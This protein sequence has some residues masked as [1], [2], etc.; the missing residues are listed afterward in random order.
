MKTFLVIA[1]VVLIAG[2]TSPATP[3]PGPANV[4]VELD[5]FSGQPNPSWTLTPAASGE[6][7]VRLRGLPEVS[8]SLPAATLGYRGFWIRN[9]GGEGGIPETVYVS[10]GGLIQVVNS[11]GESRTLQDVRAAERWLI[12]AAKKRGLGEV[13]TQ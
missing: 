9:P 12:E 11:F 7:V 2:C 6:I 8:A 13:F 3:V 1:V 4:T 5:A 10:R